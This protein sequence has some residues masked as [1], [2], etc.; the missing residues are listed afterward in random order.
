MKPPEKKRIARSEAAII[1]NQFLSKLQ[2]C[3]RV[4]RYEIAGSLRRGEPTCGDVD[5]VAAASNLDH[6]LLQIISA[7]SGIARVKL[8]EIVPD[9]GYKLVTNFLREPRIKSEIWVVAPSHYGPTLNW[10]TGSRE[11]NRALRLW[12]LLRGFKLPVGNHRFQDS[13]GL[14]WLNREAF[15]CYVFKPE[16]PSDQFASEEDFYNRIQL[17]WI[18]PGSRQPGL[19]VVLQA[20]RLWLAHRGASRK[21]SSPHPG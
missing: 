15:F 1:A 6:A 4:S 8:I 2:E 13:Q 19:K 11:H 10:A 20:H 17:N 21:E 16:P 18:P 3:D 14:W 9:V 5:I 7:V 12:C